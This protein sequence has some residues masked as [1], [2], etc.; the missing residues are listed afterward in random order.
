MVKALPLLIAI[1]LVAGCA[2]SPEPGEQ[3]PG[4]PK[5]G[6]YQSDWQAETAPVI[7]KRTGPDG[8]EK[9]ETENQQKAQGCP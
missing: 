2:S 9:Y 8:L 3:A 5:G 7:S 6:C 1:A 4:Q